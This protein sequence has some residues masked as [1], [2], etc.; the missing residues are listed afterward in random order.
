MEVEDCMM[1]N[2]NGKWNDLDCFTFQASVCEKRGNV[3]SI[4]GT[5]PTDDNCASNSACCFK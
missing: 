1:I 5:D 3:D 4:I 2:T